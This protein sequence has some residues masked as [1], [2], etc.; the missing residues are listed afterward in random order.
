[1]HLDK[2]FIIQKL[3]QMHFIKDTC[4]VAVKILKIVGVSSTKEE[5]TITSEEVTIA[6]T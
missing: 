4:I 1:M 6:L 2:C 5:V 3:L